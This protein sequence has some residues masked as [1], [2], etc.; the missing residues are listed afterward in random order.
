MAK[1]EVIFNLLSPPEK[2][3]KLVIDRPKALREVA[4]LLL[5]EAQAAFRSQGW[6]GGTR[7]PPRRAPNVAGIVRDLS[8]GGDVKARR[9][10][11]QQTLVD[12]GRLRGSFDARVDA[13]KGTVTVSNHAPYAREVHEG[14]P[15]KPLPGA[16]RP[17]P[18]RAGLVRFLRQHPELR[19][20]LGWLFGVESWAYKAVPARPLIEATK[21]VMAD[22]RKILLSH[23][24][25]ARG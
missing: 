10:S 23:R 13:E 4:A 12:T 14:G 9:L 16:K 18:I 20:D 1:V 19:K 7:W 22:I 3:A 6:R 11:D 25:G 2:F 17:G 21:P 8:E 15:R 5:S 24:L